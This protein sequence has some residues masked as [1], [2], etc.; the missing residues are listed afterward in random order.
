MPLTK[1][2]LKAY[3]GQC[4]ICDLVAHNASTGEFK[5]TWTADELQVIFTFA[6][7]ISRAKWEELKEQHTLKNLEMLLKT[8]KKKKPI[9]IDI[10]DR[11]KE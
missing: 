1:G 7:S 11:F 9:K 5:G 6:F 10:P 4:E 2:M 8:P 3:E